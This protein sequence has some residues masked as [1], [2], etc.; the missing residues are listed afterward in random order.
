MM[1]SIRVYGVGK[2]ESM[3]DLIGDLFEMS[4]I[5]RSAYVTIVLI[6]HGI[7]RNNNVPSSRLT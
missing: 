1:H 2:Q 7:G 5:D 4:G 6:S 3:K